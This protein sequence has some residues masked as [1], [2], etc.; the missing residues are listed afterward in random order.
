MLYAAIIVTITYVSLE[1]M[2]KF[3]EKE[4]LKKAEEEG[5]EVF[6]SRY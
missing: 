3:E 6:I 1:A 2:N 4:E 5:Y